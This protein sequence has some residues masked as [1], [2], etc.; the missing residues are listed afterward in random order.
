MSR[1][2][3]KHP[4]L[5]HQRRFGGDED[6]LLNLK[7][8]LFCATSLPEAV[9]NR[10]RLFSTEI[11]IMISE[12]RECGNLAQN[13]H[14]VLFSKFLTQRFIL[15]ACE[16][17]DPN[18]ASVDKAEE[19]AKLDF[20]IKMRFREVLLQKLF[21]CR[22]LFEIRNGDLDFESAKEEVYFGVIEEF[23]A[24]SVVRRFWKLDKAL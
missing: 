12:N 23:Y 21:S 9:Q 19:M 5:R 10:K 7:H 4:I 16:L 2:L 17:L 3:R 13:L 22:E 1:M 15:Q 11:W 24:D 6:A 14:V 18:Y 8:R 20:E